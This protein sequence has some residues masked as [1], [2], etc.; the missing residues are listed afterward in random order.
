MPNYTS[1]TYFNIDLPGQGI[2]NFNQAKNYTLINDN[3]TLRMKNDDMKNI[4]FDPIVT[5]IIDLINIQREQAKKDGQEIDAI[6]M[7]GGFSRSPYLQQRIRDEY[8]GVCTVTIPPE[9]VTAIS[10]GA[11]S[12]AMNP[13]MISKRCAAQSLA[14]EVQAPLEIIDQEN[15][16][17]N[18][19]TGPGGIEYVKSRLQYFVQQNQKLDGEKR[20]VYTTK[21]Q[22][23]YPNDAVFGKNSTF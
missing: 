12:Y 19:E 9:G 4:V 6:V 22:V 11:V 1:E 15:M 17:E 18:R 10:H 23:K 13:R 20:K 16:V 2:I 3:T 14:L 21:V 5:K 7:V 8:K